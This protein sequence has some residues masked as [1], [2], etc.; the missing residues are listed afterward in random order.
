MPVQ[1]EAP[2]FHVLNGVLHI[3]I[4]ITEAFPSLPENSIFLS[5]KLMNLQE[6]QIDYNYKDSWKQ[7]YEKTQID[8]DGNYKVSTVCPRWSDKIWQVY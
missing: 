2:A 3:D 7:I 6:T 5:W 4:Q 1:S 8:L